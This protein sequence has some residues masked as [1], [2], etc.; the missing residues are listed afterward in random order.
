MGNYSIVGEGLCASDE[1]GTASV[2]SVV[3]SR[4]NRP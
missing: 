1:L 2:T 4:L 3:G